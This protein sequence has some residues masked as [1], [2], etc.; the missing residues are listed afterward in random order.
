MPEPVSRRNRTAQTRAPGQRQT[1]GATS[2]LRTIACRA[3]QHSALGASSAPG[4]CREHSG[5]E[6]LLRLCRKRTRRHPSTGRLESTSRRSGERGRHARSVPLM[7][8]SGTRRSGPTLASRSSPLAVAP[9]RSP[10]RKPNERPACSGRRANAG[11]SQRDNPLTPP[12]ARAP[13][14]PTTGETEHSDV[15]AVDVQGYGARFVPR[16]VEAG[17]EHR[18]VDCPEGHAEHRDAQQHPRRSSRSHAAR[19]A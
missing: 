8:A 17:P 3:L 10:P 7:R 1:G 18:K 15:E 16:S 19:T 2:R 14:V 11:V 13:R 6:R 9:R 4:A 5:G 12:A